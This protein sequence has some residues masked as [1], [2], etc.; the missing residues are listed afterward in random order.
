MIKSTKRV[1]HGKRDSRMERIAGKVSD[2]VGINLSHIIFFNLSTIFNKNLDRPRQR[3][4]R[5]FVC[6]EKRARACHQG[7]LS[8]RHRGCFEG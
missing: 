5:E 2:K 4:S 1:V 6:P 3:E 8:S 7:R